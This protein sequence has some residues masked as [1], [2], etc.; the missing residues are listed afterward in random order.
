M[1]ISTGLLIPFLAC[2]L[3]VSTM[4]HAGNDGQGNRPD[5][6]PDWS[7]LIASMDKMH[8]AMGAIEPSG[9]DDVDFARLMLPHHRAALDMARAQ[10]QYGKDPEMRRLAQKIITGQ[11][12]EIGVM[13]RWLKQNQPAQVEINPKIPGEI[14]KPN[15]L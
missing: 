9:N 1:K 4:I 5:K 2:S 13:Q 6:G 14:A 11:Q 3:A 12:V 10:L 8:M 7:D 15:S